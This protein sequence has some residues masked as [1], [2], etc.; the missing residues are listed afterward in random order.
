MLVRKTRP[1]KIPTPRA[2]VT[3]CK[4]L[5]S[6]AFAAL[7]LL[8]AGTRRHRQDRFH[9]AADR[10]LAVDWQARNG[11]HQALRGAAGQH[12]CLQEARLILEDDVTVPDNAQRLAQ[13]LIV[14]DRM[15]LVAWLRYHADRAYHYSLATESRTAEIVKNRPTSRERASRWCKR[16]FPFVPIARWAAQ[17]G[18][19]KVGPIEPRSPLLELP[20]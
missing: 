5:F 1:L 2:K 17:N 9:P 7:D 16:P 13:R 12:R 3:M 14:D 11:C 10:A 19:R 8:M 20:A 6:A 15:T 18:I 4:L